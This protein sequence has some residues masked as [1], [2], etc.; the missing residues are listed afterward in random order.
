MFQLYEAGQLP[1]SSS[2]LVPF[3]YIDRL[4]SILFPVARIFFEKIP[5]TLD[6]GLQ[7]QSDEVGLVVVDALVVGR[8]FRASG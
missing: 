5:T 6:E 4:R 1:S 3:L 2:T 7:I 8:D